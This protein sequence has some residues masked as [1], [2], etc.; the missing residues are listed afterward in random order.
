VREFWFQNHGV[1]LF[2]V[3]EG[4]GPAI[5]MLHGGMASHVAVLPLIASL[6]SGHRVVA[7][8]LRGSGQSRSGAA[9]TFDVL[10]DDVEA[11][12]DHLSV[13]RAV[14]AGASGGSGVA[15]RFALRR[16]GR[17]AGLVIIRPVHAG[18]ARGYTR[19]QQAT[20]AAMDDAASR[21]I[22][23]GLQVLRPLY[24][25]LP[26]PMRERALAMLEGFD[27]ASVVATSHFI[28]SS[29]QPFASAEDLR[30]LRAPTLLV[31]GDDPLHPAEV[32]DIYAENVPDCTVVPASVVDVPAAILAFCEQ[33]MKRQVDS[34]APEQRGI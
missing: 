21:V 13:E 19:Q 22:D 25:N 24:A 26:P 12:L 17:I 1:R 8:D 20:F 18:E 4:S 3:E 31:R 27:A 30:S 5:V 15:V 9:L 14:V 28:A 10:A 23:E 6:G 2:G 11:L 7:P 33:T 34:Q 29:A 32:S 16:P